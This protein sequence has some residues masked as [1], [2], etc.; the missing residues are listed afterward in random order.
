MPEDDPPGKF[1]PTALGLT[2]YVLNGRGPLIVFST[3]IF[4]DL[5]VFEAVICQLCASGFSC[6]VYEHYDRG[7]SKSASPIRSGRHA[8]PFNVDLH[9][10]QLFELICHLKLETT[11]FLLVGHSMGAGVVTGFQNR[12]PE[13]VRGV[14]LIN[15]VIL[16]T[17]KPSVYYATLL[18]YVGE[19]ITEA[20]G[21]PS[22]LRF[23][24][25]AH[26]NPGHPRVR[27][28]I[29]HLAERLQ[30]PRFFAS[31]VSTL[32]NFAGLT[33]SHRPGFVLLARSDTPIMLIWGDADVS[34]PR[35]HCDSLCAIGAASGNTVR[36]EWLPGARH[37][38]F[39]PDTD[40]AAR[41]ARWIAEFSLASR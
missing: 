22:I 32:R 26:N 6:L 19:M 34:C 16:P 41:V 5:S 20:Y 1:A 4:S 38:S 2:H 36:R 33:G 27:R 3:G 8:L 37:D 14:V 10:N 7:W 18:P 13:L 23:V 35:E 25:A 9:V 17:V 11:R 31:C 30:E 12:H 21:R 28:R 24:Q 15:G 39:G 40:N 29:D